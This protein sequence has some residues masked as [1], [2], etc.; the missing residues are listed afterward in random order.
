MGTVFFVTTDSLGRGDA[1][2]G[3]L[4]MRNFL[5]S[6]ARNDEKPDTLLFMNA[7]VKVT[8]EGSDS[9]DDLRLL[10]ESGVRVLSCGTCLDYLGLKGALAVGEVGNMADSVAMLAAAASTVTLG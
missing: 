2:L 3:R 6:L 5:Y 8:C 9:L 4:L 1:E 7:G 10:A